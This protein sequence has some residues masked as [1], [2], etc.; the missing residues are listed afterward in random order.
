MLNTGALFTSTPD[1]PAPDLVCPTCG[2]PLIYRQTVLG[3]TNRSERWDYFECRTCGPFDYRHRTRK[4][5]PSID[6]LV[7]RRY[8]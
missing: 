7:T 6:K 3:G 4:L 5:R 1:S 2:L 8:S